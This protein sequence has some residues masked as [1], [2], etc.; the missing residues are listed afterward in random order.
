MVEACG[1]QGR[2]EKELPPALC[3]KNLPTMN[4]REG[5]GC[6]KTGEEAIS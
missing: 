4:W 3:L 1:L 5:V 2:T 6:E